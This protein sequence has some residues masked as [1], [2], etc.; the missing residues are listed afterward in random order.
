MDSR[1]IRTALGKLQA[2]PDAEQAWQALKEAASSEG[3]DLSRE[4]CLRLFEAARN[5]HARRGE[6]FAV[7]RLLEVSASVA[8][9][10]EHEADLVG[11]QAKVLSEELYDD[12]GAGIC[13]LRLL[14]LRPGDTG[15][16]AA[17]EE[18]Q[19]RRRR[20]HELVES[21]LAEAD[22]GADDVY[23]SSML[24]RASEL[25]VRYGGEEA[26]LEG[27][28]ERLEQA[29]RLDPTNERAGRLL[30]HVYRRAGRWEDLAG[31]LE[32]L[33]DRSEHVAERIA[34]GVRLARV[35]AGH[36]G[37]PERAARAYD[38]VLR[39][40]SDHSEAMSFLSELYS[41]QERWSDLG[42][43]YERELK[44]KDL[45]DA[46]R[47][48]D[49][50]QIAM[51]HWKKL[52]RP[53]EAEPWFERIRKVD[54][55]NE[56]MLTF[57]REYCVTLDDDTRL[58]DILQGAQRALKDG[59]K[60]KSKL[61][62][63]IGRLAEGQANAAKAIEQYKSVLRQDPDN[64]EARERLKTLYKQT[65]GHNALVELLR[66]QLERT[67]QDKY[68]ER[69]EILREVAT[70]YR[71]YQKSDTALLS[72]LNQIIQLDDKLDEHDV[73]ELREIVQL[74]EKLGRFREL[75]THQLK[76]ADVTGDVAEKQDLYRSAARRWL[77]Q[78]SNVQNATEAYAKLL[79]V[80]PGDT[81][82]RG[83][84][85]TTCTRPTWIRSKAPRGSRSSGRWHS[86]PP[87]G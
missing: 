79:K 12:D 30:E 62:Q 9:G 85:S 55:T 51:L 20:Q 29:V 4:E 61:A 46:A 67:P 26:N 6:W 22:R 73:G 2:E 10:T 52:E 32:R 58:M 69:L 68:A 17:I 28:I 50:L 48:G 36:L 21:Y 59:S 78:F 83:V 11:L 63:E 54:P 39:E 86:S 49:M 1:E 66:Q 18:S 64:V 45:H 24:M 23:K 81:E 3:G 57:Y 53:A 31:V 56:V 40:D 87:N 19:S 76:L 71:Q 25:E 82:A 77:D 5:E 43:L 38:R 37:D 42:A 34:A 8:S 72:V 27:A 47:L 60:E 14:E 65:Q 16:A 7:A 13:Y 75:V 44:S 41:S 70:V 84:S 15:A 33:A 80:A 35:Y 74:Y